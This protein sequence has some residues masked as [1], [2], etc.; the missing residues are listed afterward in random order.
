[1]SAACMQED[2]H[3][4][5]GKARDLCGSE[6]FPVTGS[7]FY[8]FALGFNDIGFVG[9]RV[10]VKEI[11]ESSG[12]LRSIRSHNRKVFLMGFTIRK[13]YGQGTGG[14]SGFGKDNQSSG[15]LVQPVNRVKGR[16]MILC[17]EKGGESFCFGSDTWLLD[18]DQEIR[19]F[20]YDFILQ[21]RSVLR[22]IFFRQ[23]E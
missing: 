22:Q 4:M 19:I 7:F 16:I 9:F 15:S 2:A 1:M 5:K 6:I 3:Q 14:C 11:T 13:Q 20:I 12:G 17:T 18:T 21:S 10:V 23:P 8:A